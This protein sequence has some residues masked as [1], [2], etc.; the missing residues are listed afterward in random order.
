MGACD[1]LAGMIAAMTSAGS[2]DVY[3]HGHHA[4]V[5]QQHARRTAE[6]DAAFLL[7]HLKPGMRLLDFGCGPGS[8]TLGLAK[9]VA[10]GGVVGIDIVEGVLAEARERAA[11][12]GVTNVRFEAGDVYQLGYEEDAFDAAYAH[13]VLQHLTRPVEALREVHR[14]LKPGGIVA[15]RDADYATFGWSP[16]SPM[17]DRWLEVYHAVAARNGAECDAGRHLRS[18]VSEAGYVDIETTGAVQIMADEASTS[19][20]GLSWS[21]RAVHSS[22][23]S[24]AVEYGIVTQAELQAISEGWRTWAQSPDAFFMYTQIEVIGRVPG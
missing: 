20:W 18:W 24:Q 14:V 17:L 12:E 5:V 19:N 21:E 23:G 22:F 15:V 6:R 3:T 10:P 13:Q 2:K 8:I 11:A 7:P 16:K 4:S 1:A 9:A